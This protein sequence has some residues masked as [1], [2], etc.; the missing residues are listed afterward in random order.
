MAMADPTSDFFDGLAQ[1]GAGRLGN[2]TASLRVD[3]D[4]G[5]ATDHWLLAIDKGNIS[6]SRKNVKADAALHT[7]QET[8]D[9]LALGEASPLAS[10]LRGLVQTEGDTE[11]I[12]LF[13]GLFPAPQNPLSRKASVDAERQPA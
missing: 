5:K 3:L 10:M 2:V 1:L 11:L 4:R 6:V 7:D 12:V 13:Q 8:F 9:R